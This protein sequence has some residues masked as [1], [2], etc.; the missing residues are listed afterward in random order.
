LPDYI[1]RIIE[2]AH[3]SLELWQL[4]VALVAVVALVTHVLNVA[5]ML[6]SENKKL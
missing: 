4:F 1:N 6:V 2:K 5:G 3:P